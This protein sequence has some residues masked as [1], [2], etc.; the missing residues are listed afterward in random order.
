[1][2]KALEIDEFVDPLFILCEFFDDFKTVKK[3]E[4]RR[5]VYKLVPC[6]RFVSGLSNQVEVL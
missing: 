4:E 6:S 2:V 1:M 5:S 3:F